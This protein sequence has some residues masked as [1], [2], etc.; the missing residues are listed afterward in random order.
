MTT[1]S[2]RVATHLV[3]GDVAGLVGSADMPDVLRIFTGVE[4]PDDLAADLTQALERS[5]TRTTR[6][7]AD[8]LARNR[9]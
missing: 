1:R 2:T 6:P 9:L 8:P 4:D 5:V 7:T 3:Q